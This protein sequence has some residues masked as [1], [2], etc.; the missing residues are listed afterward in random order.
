MDNIKEKQI[1]ILVVD[2][3]RAEL[4]LITSSL[5]KWGYST[6]TAG[7]G[8]EA[9]DIL[10]GTPA[11]IIISDQNMPGMDGMQLLHSVRELYEHIPFIM[12]TAYADTDRAVFAMRQGANDYIEKPYSNPDNLRLAVERAMKYRNLSRETGELKRYLADI[13]G[14]QNIITDS[15]AMIE[16]VKLASKVAESPDTAVAIYGES[17]VGKELLARAVHH[18]SG[19]AETR[20]VGMNCAAVPQGLL[21]SELFGCIRGAFIHR[22][23][24]KAWQ[25]RYNIL[26]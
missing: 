6:V 13:H 14:F 11:D 17:G 18:A 20:F 25:N 24:L 2:D 3:N 7:S 15:P 26:L 22:C 23:K 8:D 12:V 1:N 4:L 9:L 5:K 21:E 19:C 10:A 16:A